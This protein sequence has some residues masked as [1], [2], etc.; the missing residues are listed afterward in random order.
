MRLLTTAAL[1]LAIL[2][3]SVPCALAAKPKKSAEDR[4]AKLDVNSD[5][6]LSKEE[7]VGDKTGDAKSKAETR[8]RKLDKDKNDSLSFEEFNVMPKKAPK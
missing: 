4:F 6:K 8:F 5:K 1:L 7:F 2:T 3:L